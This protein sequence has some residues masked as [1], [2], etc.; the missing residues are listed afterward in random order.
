MSNLAMV[1]RSSTDRILTE[2]RQEVTRIVRD[3]YL[4]HDSGAATNPPSQLLRLPRGDGSRGIALPAYLGGEHPIFGIKWVTSVPQ[5]VKRNMERAAAVVV[6]N[7]YDTGVPLGIVEGSAISAVRTAA[8]AVLAA[9]SLVGS[10]AVGRLGVIGCGPINRSMLDFFV[11]ERW[12]IDQVDLFDLRQGDAEAL[13][14][15]ARE[16]LGMQSAVAGSIGEVISSAELLSLATTAITPH[17]G[18]DYPFP[19]GQVVLNISLRDLSPSLIVDAYNIVDDIE[20]CLTSQTSLHLAEQVYGNRDFVA[21]T[22]ADLLCSRVA[23]DRSRRCIFSPFGLGVLD[24]AIAF[25]VLQKAMQ[26]RCTHTIEGFFGDRVR[27]N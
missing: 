8:S 12:D 6:I 11:A 9:E 15:Y 18:D 10:R 4:L 2:C 16:R 26:E 20:H 5:N 17:I 21:G 19:S 27:W 25:F 3:V 23:A 7:D 14:A 13:G 1:D 24:L 22:L